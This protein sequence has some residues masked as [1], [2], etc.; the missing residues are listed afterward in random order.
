[1]YHF[2]MSRI[3]APVPKHARADA[4]LVR[5]DVTDAVR[6]GHVMQTPTSLGKLFVA[7]VTLE[8]SFA[9][10]STTRVIVRCIVVSVDR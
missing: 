5:L 7:N 9:G 1:M 6:G 8:R 2:H 10:F 3:T 4:A